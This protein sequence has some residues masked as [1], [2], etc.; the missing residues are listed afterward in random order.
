VRQR[1]E[2]A[3]KTLPDNEP[4]L[5]EALFTAG[6]HAIFRQNYAEAET[7]LQRALD[8]NIKAHGEES[9][10]VVANLNRLSLLGS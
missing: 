6:N 8:S 7:L 5:A 1:L 9:G 3:D 2:H 4:E 10:A